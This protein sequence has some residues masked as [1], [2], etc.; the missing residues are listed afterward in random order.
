MQKIHSEP[1]VKMLNKDRTSVTD[2]SFCPQWLYSLCLTKGCRVAQLWVPGGQS[3]RLAAGGGEGRH[4]NGLATLEKNSILL[5]NREMDL[6]HMD[7]ILLKIN[8]IFKGKEKY[9]ATMFEVFLNP[10]LWKISAQADYS[11]TI[12]T[13]ALKQTWHKPLVCFSNFFLT[14]CLLLTPC[15]VHSCFLFRKETA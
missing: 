1:Y 2:F 6:K 10:N 7:W 3:L 5:S 15:D 8:I 13:S 9:L 11:V 14:I 12:N 4:S